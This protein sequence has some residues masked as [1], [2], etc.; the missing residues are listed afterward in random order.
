MVQTVASKMYLMI[1]PASVHLQN[2]Q[3]TA[4]AAGPV[5][6]GV[7]ITIFSYE[8]AD[9]QNDSQGERN[10]S[11]TGTHVIPN[12]VLTPS[13]NEQLNLIRSLIQMQMPRR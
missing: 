5:Y 12:G 13:V 7:T 3:N 8:Q 1:K 2:T 6:I 4:L 9:R 11:H 10:T